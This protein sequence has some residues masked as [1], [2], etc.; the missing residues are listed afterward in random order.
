M[1]PQ[2]PSRGLRQPIALGT[3]GTVLLLR[4]VLEPVLGRQERASVEGWMSPRFAM[5][6]QG[7]TNSD[8]LESLGTDG[9]TPDRTLARVAD[10]RGIDRADLAAATEAPAQAREGTGARG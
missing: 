10:E 4:M 8:L 5:R 2:P 7:L 1:P 3:V 6:A 9:L